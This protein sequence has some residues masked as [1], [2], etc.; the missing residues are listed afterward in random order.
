MLP[1]PA[2]VAAEALS[3]LIVALGS[4]ASVQPLT[5]ALDWYVHPALLASES[6][7]DLQLLV[8]RVIS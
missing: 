7:V 1:N 8:A 5:A 2:D 4:K 3:G 6:V